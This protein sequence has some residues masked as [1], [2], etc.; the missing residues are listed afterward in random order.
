MV[1]QANRFATDILV[2]DNIPL[3]GIH[4]SRLIP[5]EDRGQFTETLNRIFSGS[6]ETA[7][8]ERRMMC[9]D[10]LQIW[11]NFHI[12]LQRAQDGSP[13]YCIIQIAD[14]TEMK[15]SLR[16]IERMAFYDT[17]TNLANRRLFHDRLCQATAQAQRSSNIAALLYLDLDQFKR[18]NDTLGHETGDALLQEVGQRLTQCVRRGDTV[19]RPGGDEFT[20]LL[21]NVKT[22][23]DAGVVAEKVLNVLRAP[24]QVLGHQLAITASIGITIIDEDGT[25]AGAL[26]QTGNK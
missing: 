23:T 14:I 10:G 7:R 18:V 22:P 19:G 4:I 2:Y 20:L 17:L 12:G 26:S 13:Q 9:E 5:E 1:F 3:E 16:K 21:N 24:M 11:T 15:N 6:D 8:A 25:D